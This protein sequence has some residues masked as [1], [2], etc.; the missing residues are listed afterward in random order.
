[1][2]CAPLISHSHTQILRLSLGRRNNKMRSD[3]ADLNLREK[4]GPSGPEGGGKGG[5]RKIPALMARLKEKGLNI[6]D[7]D[8]RANNPIRFITPGGNIADG[9]DAKMLP[10][11]CAVIIEAD[12]KRKLDA[13]YS[14]IA[15]RAAQRDRGS[16]HPRRPRGPTCEPEWQG[17]APTLGAR[18]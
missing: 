7:L 6:L 12:R 17:F 1:V 14:Q 5:A 2:I 13:R 16:A 8:V 3:R 15:E 10:D 18:L 11:I 9:Y 4:P